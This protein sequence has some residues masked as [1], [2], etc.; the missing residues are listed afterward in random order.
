MAKVTSKL[1]VTIPKAVADQYR[2]EPGDELEWIP[3][4]DV[5]RLVPPHVSQVR[6]SQIDRLRLFDQA[7][8]RQR[9]R[10]RTTRV[11]PHPPARGWTRS[12]LNS[13]GRSR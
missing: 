3:S 2:I 5:I 1:Q 7:T 10:N 12:D 13:R 4:G 11:P 9:A 6:F 8:D